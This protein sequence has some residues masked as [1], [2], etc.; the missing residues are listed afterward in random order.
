MKESFHSAVTPDLIIEMPPTGR[1]DDDTQIFAAD[2]M[3][4]SAWGTAAR[5]KSWTS[6]GRPAR[7]HSP[8]YYD[9]SR[10]WWR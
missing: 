4:A 2:G 10:P 6:T 5:T 3:S 1:C 7:D 8:I 9:D